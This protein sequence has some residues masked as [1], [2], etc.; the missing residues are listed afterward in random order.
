[1]YGKKT[2]KSVMV[3]AHSVIN[4]VRELYPALLRKGDRGKFHN[5][6]SVPKDYGDM[7]VSTGVEGIHL[8]EAYERGDIYINSDDE[9]CWKADDGK[10]SDDENDENDEDD[11]DD[12]EDDDTD[13]EGEWEYVNDDEDEIVIDDE[14]G[15]E[16]EVDEE[17]V[18]EE[19][20]EDD[21]DGEEDDEEGSDDD[22]SASNNEAAEDDEN[23]AQSSNKDRK[24]LDMT[25]VLSAEDFALLEKL[26]LAAAERAKDPK[27]RNKISIKDETEDGDAL[28]DDGGDSKP[29][30]SA[31]LPFN[32]E[33]TSLTP[34]M[35]VNKLTKIERISHVLKGRKESKWEHEGHAGGLTNKEK[36]RKKNYVMVRKG[37]K[38][39]ANKIRKSNSEVRWDKMHKKEIWGRDKRKRR[40]T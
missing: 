1:M 39:V 10:Y 8:L 25:R 12:G 27:Y 36:E 40:R 22:D 13:D 21:D 20:D 7:T 16:D 32:V 5:I 28:E 23:V 26:K 18:E 11:E 33:P 38:S 15:E 19:E 31:N 30:P 9:I 35:K 6:K 2:H 24:R 4:L 37:K 14:S 29:D 34:G 17:E 3:A